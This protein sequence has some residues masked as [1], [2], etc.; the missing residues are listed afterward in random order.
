MERKSPP[1]YVVRIL[2]RPR[3]R[4][5]LELLGSALTLFVVLAYAITLVQLLLEDLLAAASL[6]LFAAIPFVFVSILRSVIDLP[7]PS[8]VWGLDEIGG[9]RGSS[10]PSR[11]AASAFIVGTLLLRS[12]VP[13]AVAVLAAGVVISTLRVLL[14]KHFVIDVTVGALVGA[15]SGAIGL[16]L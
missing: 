12:S 16:I 11:H 8:A 4:R 15:L 9:K 3:L 10:F 14:G 2:S 1:K 6:A 13:L 7:R 5:S